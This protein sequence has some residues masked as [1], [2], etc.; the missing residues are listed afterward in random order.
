VTTL[1][2]DRQLVVDTSEGQPSYLLIGKNGSYIKLSPSAYHLFNRINAGA[3]LETLAAEFSQAQQ[4]TVSVE[5][6]ETAYH[7]VAERIEKIE[8]QDRNDL[9]KA[10]GFWIQFTLISEHWVA[11]VTPFL[12]GMFRRGPAMAALLGIVAAFA[13]ILPQIHRVKLT[14]GDFWWAFAL[15]QLSVVAHEFG[16]ASACAYYGVKPRDIGFAIYLIYPVFYS[17]VTAAWQLKRWQR[18]VVDLGGV[19]FQLIIGALF[20]LGY[21]W[22]HWEPLRLAFLLIFSSCLFSLNPIFKFDGYWVVADALGVVNLGKQP[23]RIL[24]YCWQRLRGQ[25]PQPLPWPLRTTLILAC[26]SI[27]SLAFWGFFISRMLPAIK[28][29]IAIYP[30]ILTNLIISLFDPAHLALGQNFRTFFTATFMTLIMVIMLS[31]LVGMVLAPLKSGVLKLIALR[32][33]L[34]H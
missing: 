12:T 20:T 31:R 9:N 27:A 3:S 28:Y 23:R 5:E 6:I 17:D 14:N 33:Q 29:Q 32:A 1:L 16:H 18:V 2:N 10:A 15:F 4:Q 26:Y 30:T 24:M 8:A 7:R 13:Y 21:F 25:R 34:L 22:W 19:F 11:R